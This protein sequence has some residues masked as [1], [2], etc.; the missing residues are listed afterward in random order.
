MLYDK[1][2]EFII[3]QLL[4]GHLSSCNDLHSLIWISQ[5]NAFLYNLAAV[6]VSCNL[7][8]ML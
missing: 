1:I 8:E 2:A 4:Y 5:Q 6:L 3:N 7:L